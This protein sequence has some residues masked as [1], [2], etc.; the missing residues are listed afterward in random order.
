MHKPRLHQRDA[1]AAACSWTAPR[2]RQCARRTQWLSIA[3]ILSESDEFAAKKISPH[4]AVRARFSRSACREWQQPRT[5]R[6]AVVRH[7]CTGVNDVKRAVKIDLP[8]S[9]GAA[10]TVLASRANADDLG[11]DELLASLA[12]KQ[13]LHRERAAARSVVAP[14]LPAEPEAS[15]SPLSPQSRQ[16]SSQRARRRREAGRAASSARG[17]LDAGRRLRRRRRGPPGARPRTRRRASASR[18]PRRSSRWRRAR[19]GAPRRRAPPRQHRRQ[20]RAA[21]PIGGGAQEGGRRRGGGGGVRLGGWVQHG[22]GPSGR[23]ASA[24]RCGRRAASPAAAARRAAPAEVP[25]DGAE[26]GA[27]GRGCKG[28]LGEWLQGDRAG[29]ALGVAH[30]P[31]RPR[32]RPPRRHAVPPPAGGGARRCLPL[33]AQLRAGLCDNW[34]Q[35]HTPPRRRRAHS[36]QALAAPRG[37]EAALL[38][39]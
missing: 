30:E 20:L 25:G 31:L 15:T 21:R 9:Q 26:G 28:E 22:G 7:R 39:R 4:R 16:A 2:Y 23:R 8:R 14:A 12:H 32:G 18:W 5:R 24:E 3:R 13:T 10:P 27:R 1:Y 6:A 36:A 11:S 19:R 33:G 35:V 29:A 38:L 17:S 37:V 34:S